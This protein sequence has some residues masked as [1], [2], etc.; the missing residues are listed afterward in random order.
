MAR[1]VPM[2]RMGVFTAL[3]RFFFLYLP[4]GVGAVIFLH[5]LGRYARDRAV[6]SLND[7]NG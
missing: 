4:A 7:G 2:A 1:M 3:Q 6:E 5:A